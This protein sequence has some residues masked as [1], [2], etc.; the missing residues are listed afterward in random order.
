MSPRRHAMKVRQF[1]RYRL[2]VI[3]VGLLLLFEVH[4]AFGQ[5]P[6]RTSWPR[7]RQRRI[8]RLQSELA[9]CSRT[10]T[11]SATLPAPLRLCSA[12]QVAL[13]KDVSSVQGIRDNQLIGYGIVVGLQNSGDSQM[14]YFPLADVAVHTCSAWGSRFR[15]HS[16][17]SW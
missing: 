7:I 15:I 8:R 17:P 2:G 16:P 5:M 1:C 14:T 4:C 13:V 9:A 11:S 12:T 10:R 6:A 3:V